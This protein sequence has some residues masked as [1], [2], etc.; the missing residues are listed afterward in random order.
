MLSVSAIEFQ[1]ITFHYNLDNTIIHNINFEIE[2][3]STTVILGKNGS[4]KST[5]LK[6][7]MRFE[8]PIDGRILIDGNLINNISIL[9]KSKILAYV[10]QDIF[11]QFDFSVQDYLLFGVTNTLN[12]ISMPNSEHRELVST[13]VK[14]FQIEHL[15]RKKMDKLSGG[16]KQIVMICRAF[17]QGSNII[18]LD[19][20]LSALDFANQNKVLKL[21]KDI[22]GKGKTIIFTTHNPN[23]ALFLDANVIF[24]YNRQIIAQ[25][26]ARE[27][28]TLDLLNTVYENSIGKSKD[29]PYE[30]FS[31]KNHEI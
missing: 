24:L 25:G 2:K 9:D 7:L 14:Q 5:L 19:E 17:I 16:E 23:H 12:F 21:L 13:Y 27:V 26:H 20:P 11:N 30:E 28:L 1:N 29:H 31:I 8:K 18:V 15:L 22:S 4:G 3:G 6:L 10:S